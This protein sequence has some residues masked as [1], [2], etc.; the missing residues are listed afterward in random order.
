MPSFISRALLFL[1]NSRA[2]KFYAISR[3]CYLF[4]SGIWLRCLFEERTPRIL[5]KYPSIWKRIQ[6]REQW[7]SLY[8]AIIVLTQ[9]TSKSDYPACWRVPSQKYLIPTYR[10]CKRWIIEWVSSVDRQM[11]KYEFLSSRWHENGKKGEKKRVATLL[12]FARVVLMNANTLFVCYNKRQY[13]NISPPV[14]NEREVAKWIFCTDSL[15]LSG[16]NWLVQ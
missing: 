10:H 7:P 3:Q 14:V 16:H 8:P 9:I 2:F 6:R 1:K 11:R 15:S 5:T 13:K 12:S 4:P